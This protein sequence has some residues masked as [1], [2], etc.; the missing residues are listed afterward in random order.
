[1]NEVVVI[2]NRRDWIG[3]KTE[4]GRHEWMK[5]FKSQ[6]LDY[7]VESSKLAYLSCD[8]NDACRHQ[9]AAAGPASGVTSSPDAGRPLARRRRRRRLGDQT[10]P[11]EPTNQNRFALCVQQLVAVTRLDGRSS[12]SMTAQRLLLPAKAADVKL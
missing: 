12:S 4:Y 2:V 11:T 9:P 8:G 7:I 6:Q 5:Q 10:T 1:M 3:I